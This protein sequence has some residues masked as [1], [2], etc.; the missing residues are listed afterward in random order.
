MQC[1]RGCS[2]VPTKKNHPTIFIADGPNQVWPEEIGELA[3]ELIERAMLS[4]K[5]RNNPLVLHSKT[6]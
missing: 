1:H 4:E 2:N 6:Y 3:G 5:I